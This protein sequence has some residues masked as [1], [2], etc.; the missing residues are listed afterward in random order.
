MV[1]I[2]IH[3]I[4][5]HYL[6]AIGLVIIFLGSYY[7]SKISIGDFG[8][9]SNLIVYKN[10]LGFKIKLILKYIFY[11]AGASF[12]I[13]AVLGYNAPDKP[14]YNIFSLFFL[15]ISPSAMFPIVK[16]LLTDGNSN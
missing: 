8:D 2:N 7:L 3:W 14:L 13:A 6:E 16:F 12:I 1:D 11:C 4:L 15:L 10:S 5:I 9:K